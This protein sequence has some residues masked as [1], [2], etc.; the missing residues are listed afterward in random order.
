MLREIL[1]CQILSTEDDK[2][3]GTG[4]VTHVRKDPS[5]EINLGLASAVV[6]VDVDNENDDTINDLIK[7]FA[8][9]KFMR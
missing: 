5:A 7:L 1:L 3:L 4:M 6:A 8:C 9:W 2:K